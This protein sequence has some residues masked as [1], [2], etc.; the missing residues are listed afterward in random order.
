MTRPPET[1]RSTS[2]TL[3]LT[4]TLSYGCGSTRGE[5]F[6]LIAELA[7]RPQSNYEASFLVLRRNPH[8]DLVGATADISI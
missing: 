1:R 6:F 5:Q 8:E 2:W 7:G 4:R 3:V